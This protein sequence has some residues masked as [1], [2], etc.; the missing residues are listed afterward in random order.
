MIPLSSLILAAATGSDVAAGAP[1]TLVFPIVCTIVMLTVW[2]V[3]LR[4]RRGE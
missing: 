2:F 3:A 1:L 4:R